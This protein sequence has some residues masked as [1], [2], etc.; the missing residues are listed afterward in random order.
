VARTITI[1]TTYLSIFTHNGP[2]EIGVSSFIR[3]IQNAKGPTNFICNWKEIETHIALVWN[4]HWH[5]INCLMWFHYSRFLLWKHHPHLNYPTQTFCFTKLQIIHFLF[6]RI[7]YCSLSQKILTMSSTFRLQYLK[8]YN[9][10]YSAM[11]VGLKFFFFFHNFEFHFQLL[12]GN[13]RS[14][15]LPFWI[16]FRVFGPLN[17]QFLFSM[18]L[19]LLLLSEGISQEID[20][21]LEKETILN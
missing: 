3:L 2:I 1:L 11:G 19:Q 17:L 14:Q 5:N 4:K 18:F 13:F 21:T 15:C 20:I 12:D 8:V 16:G 9:I 7:I 6:K 10:L